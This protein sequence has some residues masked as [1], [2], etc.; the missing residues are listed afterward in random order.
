M[1]LW[2]DA[3]ASVWL[4]VSGRGVGGVLSPC[5]VSG[6][7]FVVFVGDW[8]SGR[9]VFVSGD[10]VFV[11]GDDVSVFDVVSVLSGG[12]GGIQLGSMR[13]PSLQQTSFSWPPVGWFTTPP[14]SRT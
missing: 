13:S 6:A 2:H 7:L 12:A 5:E 3:G 8:V 4:V 14:A 10:D 11:S 9:D 1:L